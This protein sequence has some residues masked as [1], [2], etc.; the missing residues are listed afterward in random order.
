MRSTSSR[1]LDFQVVCSARTTLLARSS[2]NG[3]K[4]PL[5]RLTQNVEFMSHFYLH[6]MLTYI[7][8]KGYFDR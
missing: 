7:R 3:R 1:R 4:S 2:P 5:A 6:L 8:H